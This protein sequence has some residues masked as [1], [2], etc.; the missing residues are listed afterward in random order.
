[1]CSLVI[2][3]SY[4]FFGYYT[5]GFLFSRPI[6]LLRRPGHPRLKNDVWENTKLKTWYVYM[7]DHLLF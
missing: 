2:I 1:M 5:N 3:P 6:D 4:V 7:K